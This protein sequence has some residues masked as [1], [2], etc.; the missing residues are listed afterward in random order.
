MT[1]AIDTVG[2]GALCIDLVGVASVAAAGQGYIANPEGVNLLILRTTLV[3]LVPSALAGVL[4]V[5]IAAVTVSAADIVNALAMNV[6]AGYCYN[7]HA[8]QTTAKTQISGPAI[9]TP[10]TYITF[11]GA[12]YSL[13]GLHAKLFVEYLRID[14]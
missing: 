3:V 1:V 5:G 4:S 2:K 9:W 8:P 14:A 6:T 7:G 11:S 12:S 10:T 13:A